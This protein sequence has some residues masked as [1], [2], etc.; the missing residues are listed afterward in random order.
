MHST[1]RLKLIAHQNSITFNKAR[2]SYSKQREKSIRWIIDLGIE[3]TR[4]TFLN[5]TSQQQEAK[6]FDAEK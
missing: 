4:V 2:L 6:K 5:P 1:A 3:L